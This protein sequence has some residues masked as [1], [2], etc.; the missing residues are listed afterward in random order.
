MVLQVLAVHTGWLTYFRAP[1][2][3]RTGRLQTLPPERPVTKSTRILRSANQWL[4][5][6]LAGQHFTDRDVLRD[7]YLAITAAGA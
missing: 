3:R 7:P 2:H 4:V 1:E 5:R 6:M